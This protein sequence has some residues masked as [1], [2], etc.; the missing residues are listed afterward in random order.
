MALS[1]S[2]AAPAHVNGIRAPSPGED[3]ELYTQLLRLQDVV[4]AG[5]HPVFKL[6]QS[7]IEQLKAALSVP[8]IAGAANGTAF[9]TNQHQSQPP[10]AKVNGLPGLHAP[11]TPTT[12][13]AT[14]AYAARAAGLDPIFLQKSDSLVRAEGQLKRQ[15]IERDLHAQVDQRKHSSRDRDQGVEGPSRIDMDAVLNAALIF[16]PPVSGLKPAKAASITSFDEND[17]YSSQAPSEWSS[18]A[19]PSKGSDKGTGAFTADFERLGAAAAAATQPSTSFAESSRYAQKRPMPGSSLTHVSKDRPHSDDVYNVEE[20]DD[21]YTP[22]DAATFDNFRGDGTALDTQQDTPPED[23]NSDYEPGEITHESAMPSPRY[24]TAR[25][26][27]LSPRV[28]VIRNHLTHIAAPQPNRVSPFATAKGPSIEL[29]LVNGRPEIVH[30]P[31]PQQRSVPMHSRASTAS[32]SGNAPGGSGKKARRT[33]KRK[34]DHIHEQAKPVKKGRRDR[35]APRA[36][37]PVQQQPHIKDE[38][39]S[40]PPFTN[41]PEAPIQGQPQYRP[42]PAQ[43]DLVSPGQ[44]PQVQYV[45]EPPRS[46]LRHEYTQPASPAV[47]RIASPGGYR[48]V[49]RDTQDLRRVA[50]LQYAQRPPSPSQRVYSPAGPYRAA[51]AAYGEQRPPQLAPAPESE[52]APRYRDMPVQSEVQ[53]VRAP[54]PPRMQEYQEAYTRA[55]SPVVM[56]PPPPR[57]IIVDQFGNR[58]YAA[59]SAPAPSRA[60]VAPVDR[61]IEPQPM[62]ERAPSRMSV[63][64]APPPQAAPYEPVDARMLPPPPLARRQEQPV[65]Y[66]DANGYRIAREYSTRPAEP[67][68]YAEAPTSPVYQQAPRYEQIPAPPPASER[69]SP[70]YQQTRRYEQMPPPPPPH[71]QPAREP[72]SPVYQQMPRAYSVRPEEP[73]QATP[74]YMRQASVAPVQYAR[75]E[76]APPPPPARAVSVMPGSDY[77]AQA[78]Q[79]AYSYAPAPQTV[80]Y[81]DM[82]G[83]EVYPQQVRQVSEFRY[84]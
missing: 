41:V 20:E 82:Y 48:P 56:A 9:A 12:N 7:T 70:V 30:K 44:P 78:Q 32:P 50:S 55:Q 13:G 74:V 22:P 45:N 75:Q 40:P 33:K 66:V 53:Y 42:A 11:A 3:R 35:P 81:V 68:R 84:Q 26:F 83:R 67:M 60:S 37:S 59:E 57:R 80:K 19:S 14:S 27:H 77:G 4:L 21:E 31:Q 63:A 25:S 64:Y 46:G 49:Q 34:R 71:A 69:T 17:Y 15:R 29:E 6:P 61:M 16:V 24:Q 54:S 52:E 79:P 28:P 23:D 1:V 65:E 47:V 2:N 8:E 72:T 43:I 18:D 36:V 10:Y 39:V 5:K 58:F 73:P 62:Y 76:M 51:S 38:P